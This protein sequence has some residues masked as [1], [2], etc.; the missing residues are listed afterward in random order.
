MG[1][2]TGGVEG[3][4]AERLLALSGGVDL[5]VLESRARGSLRWLVLG[6]VCGRVVSEARCTVLVLPP[7]REVAN[8]AHAPSLAGVSPAGADDSQAV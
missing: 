2:A 7:C 4:P 3:D 6:S 8:D 5:L 1:P